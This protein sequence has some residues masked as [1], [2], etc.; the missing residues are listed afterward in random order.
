M[1]LFVAADLSDEQREELRALVEEAKQTASFDYIRWIPEENWHATLAFIGDKEPAE[2]AK[3]EQLT[4]EC[5]ARKQVIQGQPSRIQAFPHRDKPRLLAFK[6]NPGVEIQELHWLLTQALGI[7]ERE[8][9][10]RLHVTVAR[11]RE[12]G[13]EAANE[14]NQAIKDLSTAKPELWTFPSATIYESVLKQSGAEY[15]AIQTWRI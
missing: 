14:L 5:I 11:F 12:L 8:R 6:L 3:V 15:K 10:F 1:R 13:K 2:A 4:G 7:K 9:N